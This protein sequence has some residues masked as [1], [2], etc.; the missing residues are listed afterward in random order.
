MNAPCSG[1]ICILEI[2]PSFAVSPISASCTASGGV[3]CATRYSWISGDRKNDFGAS[4]IG[5][6]RRWERSRSADAGATRSGGLWVGPGGPGPAWPGSNG[7]TF[8][9]Y[10]QELDDTWHTSQDGR[11]G[12]DRT[13]GGDRRRRDPGGRGLSGRVAGL[14]PLPG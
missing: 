13:R 7:L 10:H 8:F 3:P 6:E 11:L 9:R 12:R 14:Q 1:A 4:A 5:A 2:P